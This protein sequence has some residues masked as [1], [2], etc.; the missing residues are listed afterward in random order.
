M[1]YR[2]DSE[3]SDCSYGCTYTKTSRNEQHSKFVKSLR[4]EFEK[5][6]NSAV[7]FVSNCDSKYR[8]KFASS[9]KTHFPLKV[10]GSCG[11]W[12]CSAKE[13]CL[14]NFIFNLFGDSCARYSDCELNE[15]NRNKFYLSFES[16]N[17]SNYLTEK[18]WRILR[19]NLIPVVLQ[20]SRQFYQLNAPPNSF[21]HAEDFDYDPVKLATYLKRVAS[22]FELYFKHLEWKFYTDVVYSQTQCETRR[23]CELCTKLNTERNVIYYEKVSEWFNNN[24]VVN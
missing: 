8:M 22:N 20:P 23:F 15:F 13:N 24:C 1:S 19:T 16:K 17:C 6:A 2:I 11:K 5:R 14:N 21:I 4:V 18:L 9:L 12:V 7:W 3:V 10:F